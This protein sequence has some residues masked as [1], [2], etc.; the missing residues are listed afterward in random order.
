MRGNMA[1]TPSRLK[2]TVRSKYTFPEFLLFKFPL[3]VFVGLLYGMLAWTIVVSFSNWR[4]TAPN[5]DFAGLKW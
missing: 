3:L 2:R 1:S 5:F 4:G